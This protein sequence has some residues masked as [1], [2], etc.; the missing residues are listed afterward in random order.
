MAIAHP[1]TLK[2]QAR[3]QFVLFKLNAWRILKKLSAVNVY[4]YFRLKT[5]WIIVLSSLK[6]RRV[7]STYCLVSGVLVST[8]V[9]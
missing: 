3:I 8:T 5:T 9:N 1:L 6:G 2:S 7:Q 4:S